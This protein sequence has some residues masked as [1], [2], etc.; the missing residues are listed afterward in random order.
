[1]K[2]T[3]P[4]P[5]GLGKQLVD[6]MTVSSIA[7]FDKH[8]EQFRSV[9][10]QRSKAIDELIMFAEGD[11]FYYKKTAIEL[12]GVLH[13]VQLEDKL[14][15]IFQEQFTFE[16]LRE[17]QENPVKITNDHVVLQTLMTALF[18][19]DTEKG[20]RIV[21]EVMSMF[22]GTWIETSLNAMISLRSRER[23]T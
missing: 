6:S 4:T 22:L 17:L 23:N 18:F 5:D 12:I 11:N 19:L 14:I 7:A 9:P 2:T 8:V 20:L 13:I 3:G 16:K 15:A 21:K 10:E 1:M